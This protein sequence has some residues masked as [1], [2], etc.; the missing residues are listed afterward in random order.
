MS[1]LTVT[2]N[3]WP[4]VLSVLATTFLSAMEST[5]VSTAMPT[6]AAAL[7]GVELYSWVFTAY[8]MT[9]TVT[10]P[11]WGKL[12]D[13][14][15][16]KRTLM[17]G[18]VLFL[19]GSALCGRSGSMVQLILFR[20]LQG[21]GAGAVLPVTMTIFGD[22]F[23]VAERARYQGLLGSVW[24]F[25]ALVGP[26]LGSAILSTLGWRWIFYVNL[27]IGV[28][29]ALLLAVYLREQVPDRRSRLDWAG[30]GLLSGAVTAVLLAMALGGTYRPWGDP[31]VVGLLALGLILG[32]A[33]VWVEA[34]AAEP[35]LP[36]DLF[37]V[38]I[39]GAASAASVFFG[40]VLFATSAYVPL[41]VQG[42]LGRD[43]RTTALV[44]T[45][46]SIAW[47]IASALS[48]RAILRWGFRPSAVLGH[49]LQ[50]LAM[51][52][53]IGLW[54]LWLRLPAG[55]ATGLA[56][57]ITL[58]AGAGFGLS[59]SA[60]FIGVQNAV[61]WTRRG[62][63][64]GTLTF[65]RALGQTVG[66]AVLGSLLGA[67]LRAGLAGIPGLEVGDLPLGRGGG[68]E[69]A[70]AG[71][72][73]LAPVRQA[74]LDAVGAVLL[75]TVGA[76]VLGLLFSLRVPPGVPAPTGAATGGPA[77]AA[78]GRRRLAGNHPGGK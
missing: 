60:Y 29:A 31:V 69:A 11:L 37:R 26:A 47:P 8:L 70:V 74:F 41:F 14:F 62:V 55:T 19:T 23:D 71:I 5:V 28:V 72:A 50:L 24:G 18:V 25:S 59:N 63:A 30:A 58:T 43:Q 15:G 56:L 6:V 9:T 12:A 22:L 73:S 44:V 51:V 57:G 64:T 40:V 45:S 75:A 42:V 3:R 39:I 27:P 33:F 52:L 4:I 32:L 48:A 16:R 46:M 7:G 77:E 13:L 36:L 67:R 53:W 54:P 35:I 20:A 1:H 2:G 61:P 78:A 34:R 38:P 68:L 65:I 21:L 76:A 17:A 66:G 10:T 49:T